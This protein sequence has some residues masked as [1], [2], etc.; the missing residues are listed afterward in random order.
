MALPT[1]EEAAQGWNGNGELPPLDTMLEIKGSDFMGDWY[2]T[3]K[4]VWKQGRKGNKFRK[5]VGEGMMAFKSRPLSKGD[6]ELWR[7]PHPSQ[8]K[9]KK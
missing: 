5:W 4:S 6:V 1:A 2:S 3:A 9:E 8:E 7:L